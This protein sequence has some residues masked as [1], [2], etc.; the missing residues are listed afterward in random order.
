M[1]SLGEV[2]A[3]TFDCWGTLLYEPD[4]MRSFGPRVDQ[5]IFVV[6]GTSDYADDCAPGPEKR[7]EKLVYLKGY[8]EFKGTLD[9][10][11]RVTAGNGMNGTTG[12]NV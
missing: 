8:Q 9:L 12:S 5:G 1:T 10:A 11:F 2:R 3:V 6:C 7:K 4:P